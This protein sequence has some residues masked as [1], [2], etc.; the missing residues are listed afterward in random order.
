MGGEGGG[1]SVTHKQQQQGP[2]NTCLQ[3]DNTVVGTDHASWRPSEPHPI[4]MHGACRERAC[5]HLLLHPRTG[6]KAAIS[7]PTLSVRPC[8]LEQPPTHS[9]LPTRSR[10]MSMSTAMMLRIMEAGNGSAPGTSSCTLGTGSRGGGHRAA[11]QRTRRP[12]QHDGSNPTQP[13][14]FGAT[15]SEA[16]APSAKGSAAKLSQRQPHAGVVRQGSLTTRTA[17][18]VGSKYSSGSRSRSPSTSSTDPSGSSKGCVG[19]TLQHLQGGVT[20]RQASAVQGGRRHLLYSLG[21]G[22]GVQPWKSN[23]SR[24]APTAPLWGRHWHGQWPP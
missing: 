2:P 22:L 16:C 14:L 18:G 20:S 7:L 19:T 21:W 23:S 13:E 24:L 9:T 4:P 3:K 15:R 17:T 1:V 12:K 11:L 6:A 10:R 8:M 5:R